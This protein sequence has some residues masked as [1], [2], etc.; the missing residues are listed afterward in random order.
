MH[1]GT[2]IRPDVTRLHQ[3]D[4]ALAPWCPHPSQNGKEPNPCLVLAPDFDGGLGMRTLDLSNRV[5]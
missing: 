5:A 3:G 4:W 1:E 2:D